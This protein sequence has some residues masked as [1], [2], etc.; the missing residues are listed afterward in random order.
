MRDK[1]VLHSIGIHDGSFHADEVT[2]CALLILFKLADK[3][4]IRR[5]REEEILSSCEYVCDVGGKYDPK[6]K[7]FDHHQ[8]DYKGPLSSAGMILLYLKD[9]KIIDEG[10]Y[11][12]LNRSLII[13]VDKEDNGAITPPEGVCTFSEVLNNFMPIEYTASF[14]EV[15]KAFKEA[16]D[17]T[18]WYLD[19]LQKR[20]EYFLRCRA[21]VKKS[22]ELNKDFLLIEESIPWMENF[23][24]LGGEKH[25]ALFVIMPTGKHWKLRGI[26]PNLKDKM[27]V[28]MSLP[29]KWAGL[30]NDDL[31]K[32]SNIKG[33]IFCH[34]G[35]FIS[36][37]ETKEDAFKALEYVLKEGKL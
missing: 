19:R 13:G 23:F 6:M 16:L 22:M 35:G 33:A 9:K 25:R 37:W 11:E 21:L 4:L 2:A 3:D 27:S 28:R 12:F 24:A 36:I 1:V 30:H 15:G 5:T 29:K 7:L 8:S 32:V 14:E 26:P 20:Y 31:K 34:K 18:L 17:F 10:F